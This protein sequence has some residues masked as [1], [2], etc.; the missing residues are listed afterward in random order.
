MAEH[1]PQHHNGNGHGV[2][3]EQSDTGA[4]I[5]VYSVIGLTVGM[6]IVCLIVVALF[7]GF[8]E[9]LPKDAPAS[10]MANTQV[11]PPEPR[12]QEH[13]A[14]EIKA[15]RQRNDEVLNRYAWV[16]QKAGVVRLPIEKAIDI[17]AKRGF[18]T[19]PEATSSNASSNAK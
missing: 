6:V 1:L 2:G 3:Y 13:P 7:K 5:I 11:Y 8:Q 9:L 19:R 10:R 18:P 15:L 17:M 16:D 14:D 12:L 4:R